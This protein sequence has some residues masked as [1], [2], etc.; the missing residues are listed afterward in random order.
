MEEKKKKMTKNEAIQELMAAAVRDVN[1]SGMGM[2]G[3]KTPEQ[4]DKTKEAIV[5]MWEFQN[6]RKITAN[7]IFNLGIHYQNR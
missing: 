4:L 2:R 5:T 1:G 3:E 7:E 6:K